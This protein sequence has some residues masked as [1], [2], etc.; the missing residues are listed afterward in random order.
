M[1][2][3]IPVDDPVP[4]VGKVGPPPVGGA[5][6]IVAGVCPPAAVVPAIVTVDTEVEVEALLKMKRIKE[7]VLIN[8]ILD[9]VF[10]LLAIITFTI[11]VK[12]V[13]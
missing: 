8:P 2:I 3:S 11:V 6:E 1:R 13:W 9:E 10:R 4:S 12:P 5:K 7:S